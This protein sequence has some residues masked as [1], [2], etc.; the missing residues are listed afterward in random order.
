MISVGCQ[1]CFEWLCT[2]IT[3]PG[4]GGSG[5]SSKWG[6]DRISS[7]NVEKLRPQALQSPLCCLVLAVVCCCLHLEHPSFPDPQSACWSKL[8][9]LKKLSGWMWQQWGAVKHL[10]AFGVPMEPFSKENPL[11][12]WLLVVFSC[13]VLQT[14]R[15]FSCRAVC[16]LA[17]LSLFGSIFHVT[18]DMIWA[19]LGFCMDA[20]QLKRLESLL[21]YIIHFSTTW[22]YFD[23]WGE[24]THYV[25]WTANMASYRREAKTQS[26]RKEESISF[27]WNKK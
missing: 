10:P 4:W 9:C 20:T 19:Y 5:W 17:L 18:F 23:D 12:P 8:N 7:F 6:L 27:T 2:P 14:A 11:L 16:S 3:V 13:C 24:P 15:V 26:C 21:F 1:Q 22:V 25:S